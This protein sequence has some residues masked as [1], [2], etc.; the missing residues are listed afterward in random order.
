[1]EKSTAIQ[2]STTLS[3]TNRKYMQHFL[4]EYGY[5]YDGTPEKDSKLP[6]EINFKQIQAFLKRVLSF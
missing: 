6:K 3:K 5:A 4:G 1:M 2:C